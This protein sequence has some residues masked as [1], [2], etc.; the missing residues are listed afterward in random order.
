MSETPDLPAHPA[1]A[2]LAAV[3]DALAQLSSANLWSMS[4]SDV[5]DLRIGLEAT[6]ARLESVTL[7]V[8]REVDGRGAATATGAPSTAAWLRG[9]LRLHPGAAKAEVELAR[10]LHTDLTDTA[11]ALAAGDISRDA[12][13]AVAA[14]LGR[15]PRG[16]EA[17]TR[18]AAQ[19]Y[20]VAR[21]REFDPAALARLGN[22]LIVALDPEG[23]PALEREEARQADRQYLTM[24]HAADGSRPLRGQFGPEGGAL[25]DAVLQS[26]SGP[27]PRADGS[28]EPRPNAA[29]KASSSC[30]GTWSAAGTTC[31]ST[32]ANRS[33]SPSRPPP[34][35]SPLSPT[36]APTPTSGP[37]PEPTRR[38]PAGRPGRQRP[39]T[40]APRCPRR[41]P[42]GSAATPGW[43][44]PSSTPTATS[45]TSAGCHASSPDPS[46]AHW[47]SATAAAHSPAAAAPPAGATPTTSGSGPTADP[48]SCRTWCCSAD[49]TTESS[50][51]TAGTSTSDPTG[52]HA[53]T[54]HP[55]STPTKYHDQPGDHPTSPPTTDA[56]SIR[57]VWEAFHVS[58]ARRRSAVGRGTN[59]GVTAA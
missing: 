47:L 3:D 20:L 21:A 4:E 59:R 54:R 30:S 46:A 43:S 51:T 52:T 28:P 15:L 13:A 49:T 19:T 41:P 40:T 5:L 16:V 23:G 36:P 14:G 38:A 42:D 55:G 53:S 35:T 32:A 39:S 44:P 27:V 7:A 33:P 12:A 50:T 8:T 58:P 57:L 10:D 31:P 18:D 22:H 6:R 37:L 9:R 2:A 26:L 34:T 11:A 29:P 56:G 45:W 24:S 25:L 48:P 1:R 17:A